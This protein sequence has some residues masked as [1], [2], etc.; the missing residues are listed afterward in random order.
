MACILAVPARFKANAVDSRVD[1]RNA[2][3]GLDLISHG[4]PGNVDGLAAET[5]GLGQAFDDP[6]SNNYH[7]RSEQLA[8]RGASEPDRS[9]PGNVD[10]RPRTDSGGDGA[11]EPRRENIRQTGEI[12]DLRHR[13]VSVREPQQ[14]EV[15]IWDHHVLGL[16]SNPPPHVD[17]AVGGTGA[18]R[19][20]VEANARLSFLAVATATAGNVERHRYE[21]AHLYK[22][23]V[24][25]RL[26]DLSGDLVT[27][28]EPGRC[29][30]TA[31]HHV[32][33]APA[34]V[35]A[36]DLEDDAVVAAATP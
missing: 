26:D 13:L 27:E 23:D 19:V 22:L 3:D 31:P 15:S 34:N 32:L 9:R 10:N 6:V 12:L 20:H 2:D 11:V 21:V 36:H 35:G 25:P 29:R 8:G 4:P 14:V 28:D 33:V 5:A 30:G 16:S 17:I 1:L 24:T 7:C 18:C